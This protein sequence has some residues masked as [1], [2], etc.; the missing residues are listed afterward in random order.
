VRQQRIRRGRADVEEERAVVGEDAFHLGGPGAAPFEELA[1]AG[2]VVE[3][4]VVDAEV[5]GRG[6]DDEVDGAVGEGGEN[7][8][9]VAVVEV[10]R[11]HGTNRG[12]TE[13]AEGTGRGRGGEGER[14]ERGRREEGE[15]KERGR[16]EAEV[17]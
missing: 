2:G 8:E 7:L 1:A 4:A 14:K 16:R 3:G 13:V 17:P 5:V 6:G 10:E 11:G 9:A 12:D 15:R